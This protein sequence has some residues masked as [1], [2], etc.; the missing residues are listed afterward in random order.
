MVGR[1]TKEAGGEQVL[2]NDMVDGWAKLLLLLV[3]TLACGF[4]LCAGFY[5]EMSRIV[6]AVPGSGVKE[7][8]SFSQMGCYTLVG[9]RV[10]VSRSLTGILERKRGGKG[11]GIGKGDYQGGLRF[12]VRVESA[13]IFRK[14]LRWSVPRCLAMKV[15]DT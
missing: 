3:P 11:E 4:S 5:L 10:S 1:G 2:R 6:T 12:G 8:F 14:A 15:S 13:M 7:I 9:E